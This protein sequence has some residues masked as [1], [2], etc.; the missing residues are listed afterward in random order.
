MAPGPLPFNPALPWSH[1]T[2]LR[3]WPYLVLF[4]EI[5]LARIYDCCKRH[6]HVQYNTDITSVNIKPLR[7]EDLLPYVLFFSNYF[8]CLFGFFKQIGYAIE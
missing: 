8:M 5:H 4:D 3:P 7:M 1:L 2:L 6:S